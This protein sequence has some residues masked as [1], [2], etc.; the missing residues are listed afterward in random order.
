[1]KKLITT[2]V[3][4]AAVS[5]VSVAHP[6]KAGNTKGNKATT[7]TSTPEQIAEKNA[8][9]HQTELGLTPDQYKGVYNAELERAR[10]DA[11]ARTGGGTPGDGQVM[12]MNISRDQRIKAA[13]TADQFAKYQSLHPATY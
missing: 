8:K 1:M 3:L 2:C 9:M 10:Q 12:Q 6:Q 13:V 7:A 11:Q 5:M 4:L